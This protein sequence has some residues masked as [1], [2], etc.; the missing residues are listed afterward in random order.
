MWKMLEEKE[1]K[2]ACW[3]T[4]EQQ[5]WN[6]SSNYATSGNTWRYLERL[7]GTC[8]PGSPGPRAAS[9]SRLVTARKSLVSCMARE[10]GPQLSDNLCDYHTCIKNPKCYFISASDTDT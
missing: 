8:R 2:L 4:P 6:T 1:N 5:C 7:L 3:V 9:I 10:H